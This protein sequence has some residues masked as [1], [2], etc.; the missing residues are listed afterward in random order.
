MSRPELVT[1]DGLP[2]ASG[3]AHAMRTRKPSAAAAKFDAFLGACTTPARDS[4]SVLRIRAGGAEARSEHWRALATEMLGGPSRT[5]RTHQEWR[6]RQDRLSDVL[7]ALDAATSDDVT[8]FGSPLA[9][10]VLSAAVR[11]VDPNDGAP[12]AGVSAEA[13]GG[14]AV[15]GYG[16]TLGAS[17]VRAAFGTTASSL[18]LWL[19]FPGDVRLDAA[20]SHVQ[21]HAPVRLSAKHWRRWT[22]TR[23]GDGYGSAR[24]PSPLTR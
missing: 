9:A 15:D 5:E 6:V 4:S 3:G 7:A 13:T 14:F 8:R 19:A 20:A 21:A 16:R 24:I 12:Y 1:Y 23:S 18:S 17:G 10:L 11:L 2:A 22:P